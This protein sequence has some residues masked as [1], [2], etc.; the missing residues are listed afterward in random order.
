MSPRKVCPCVFD[1]SSLMPL[2]LRMCQRYGIS[3]VK[4]W[5]F[6]SFIDKCAFLSFS[7]ICLMWL[8][9]SSA[10]LWKIMISSRYGM[11]NVKSFKTPVMSSWKYTGACASSKGTFMYSYFPNGEVNAVLGIDDSSNGM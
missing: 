6:L 1:G 9:C 5:H 2:G 10:V 3:L 4:K 11:V 7:K 8:R